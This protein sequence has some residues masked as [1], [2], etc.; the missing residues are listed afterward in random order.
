MDKEYWEKI[1]GNYDGEIFD[2]L[3]NDTNDVIIA[4]LRHIASSQKTIADAGCGIGKWLSL[5]SSLFGNIVAIDISDANIE[6]ARKKYKRLK[7]VVFENGDIASGL[8][9]PDLFDAILCV[10]AVIT[11]SYS[12]RDNFF[13]N[14]SLS[15]THGGSLILVVP[16]LESALY[17]DYIFDKCNR[18]NGFLQKKKLGKVD[19][20]L[21]Q[22]LKTGIINLDGVPTKHYLEEELTDTLNEFGFE[23]QEI[24][25][26]EYNWNTE[27]E[28]PPKWLEDPYPWDWAVLAKKSE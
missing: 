12:K 3:E 22:N 20:A 25:K 1:S 23:I 16:S 19:G 8:N 24:T 4:F 18:K 6:Y 28:M 13:K 9:Y 10:N 14:L 2:V 5:L 15:L 21:L 26:V 17:V 27:I 7:N 11:D